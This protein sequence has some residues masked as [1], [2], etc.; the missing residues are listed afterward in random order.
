M[1]AHVCVVGFVNISVSLLHKCHQ[2]H[3][4]DAYSPQKA[5]TS[6][7]VYVLIGCIKNHVHVMS[8]M[9]KVQG[10]FFHRDIFNEQ[11]RATVSLNTRRFF[12]TWLL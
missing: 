3:L 11:T 1:T 8:Q 12:N 6:L 7:G 10:V 5:W 4:G 2:T 9:M